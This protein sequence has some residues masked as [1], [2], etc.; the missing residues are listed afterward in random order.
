MD[1]E[2]KYDIFSY[3]QEYDRFATNFQKFEC[4]DHDEYFIS[5]YQVM[6]TDSKTLQNKSCK[7]LKNAFMLWCEKR[8]E[9]DIID[10]G[11]IEL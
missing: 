4:E 8:K 10:T 2:L 6:E 3:I 1:K 5:H 11:I 9:Q 7:V